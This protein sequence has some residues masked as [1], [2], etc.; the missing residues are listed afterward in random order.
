MAGAAGLATRD[1]TAACAARAQSLWGV[2]AL[3]AGGCFSDAPWNDWSCT[4]VGATDMRLDGSFEWAS[5]AAF[6]YSNWGAWEPST[7]VG[8]GSGS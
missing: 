2:A 6:N 3:G 7:S 4:W 8:D 5:G 1:A